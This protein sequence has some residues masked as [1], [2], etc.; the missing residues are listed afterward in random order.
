VEGAFSARHGDALLEP[1][2]GR[3]EPKLQ[4][5]SRH[6]E[7]R[8]PLPEGALPDARFDYVIDLVPEHPVGAAG[9]LDQWSALER[10]F[11]RRAVLAASD[12]HGWRPLNAGDTDP[13]A[14]VRAGLQL[15]SR[16]GP[17]S[18]ADL[19]EFRSAV[20]TLGAKL[21]ASISAPEMREAVESAR[22]LDGLCA[23]ADI[24]VAL[25][26]VPGANGA[27]FGEDAA[28]SAA[29]RTAGGPFSLDLRRGK[30][31]GVEAITLIMDVPRVADVVRSFEAMAR[32]GRQLAESL[33]GRLVDDNENTLDERSLSAI[34][35]QLE[36][37]R[38]RLSGRGIEPGGELALR[39]FS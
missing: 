32:T 20:E 12:E 30:G 38:Q 34:A 15:A 17:V 3:R 37:V 4:G 23:D 14:A 28:I 7:R 24:Q 35:A 22:E 39:L 10:R 11:A 8:E 36:T 13:C 6:A 2:P 33:G 27:P 29:D 18:E 1:D 5:T 9:V 25:H 31:A 26:V 21:G 19:L 16:D